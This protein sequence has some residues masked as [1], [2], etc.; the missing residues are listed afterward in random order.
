[1]PIYVA[2]TVQ[3]RDRQGCHRSPRWRSCQRRLPQCT[4]GCTASRH[5]S[6][7]GSQSDTLVGELERGYRVVASRVR[8]L[9]TRRVLPGRV[10][11]RGKFLEMTWLA[12][13]TSSSCRGFV[14]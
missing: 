2:Q 10:A 1:M 3:K 8:E 4:P 11:H 6:L 5:V 14:P 9:V 7:E 12:F 13:P